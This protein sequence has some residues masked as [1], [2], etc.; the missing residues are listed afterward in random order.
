MIP[1]YFFDSGIWRL[2]NLAPF[3]GRCARVVCT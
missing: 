3:C 2:S 1:R